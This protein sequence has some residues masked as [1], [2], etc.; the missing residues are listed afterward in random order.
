MAVFTVVI[1]KDQTIQVDYAW[2]QT[3]VLK[4]IY[5]LLEQ[6]LVCT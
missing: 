2:L 3:N 5:Y 1:Y 4:S 6:G